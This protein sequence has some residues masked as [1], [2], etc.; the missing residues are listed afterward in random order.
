MQLK[1]AMSEN[2]FSNVSQTRG[3]ASMQAGEA[4]CL[5]KLRPNFSDLI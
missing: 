4:F 2:G 3:V 5:N 1:V